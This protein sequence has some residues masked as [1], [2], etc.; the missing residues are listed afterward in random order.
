MLSSYVLLR[1]EDGGEFYVTTPEDYSVTADTAHAAFADEGGYIVMA[2]AVT[3]LQS[4]DGCVEA[5]S[6][7][8]PPTDGSS[9][10]AGGMASCRDPRH[11]AVLGAT[12]QAARRRGARP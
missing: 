8:R 9:A 4:H 11:I 1:N 10:G 2:E 7:L 6:L 5:G 3:N 12:P